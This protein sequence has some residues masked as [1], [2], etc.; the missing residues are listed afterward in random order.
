M[1]VQMRET[2]VTLLLC[3]VVEQLSLTLWREL[4]N[5]EA[6]RSASR[7]GRSTGN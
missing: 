5:H 1:H 4:T 2:T 3:V 6:E 7:Y